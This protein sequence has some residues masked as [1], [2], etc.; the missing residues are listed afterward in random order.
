MPAHARARQRH[1]AL[2][3]DCDRHG[4][5]SEG[6]TEDE[7]VWRVPL[8]RRVHA[9]S[10]DRSGPT[11]ATAACS[12][13]TPPQPLVAAAE[14]AAANSRSPRS[15][16]TMAP[17]VSE[18]APSAARAAWAGPLR[19]ARRRRCVRIRC[20]YA[21]RRARGVTASRV[22]SG[23]RSGPRPWRSP[24]PPPY[25]NALARSWRARACA[26]VYVSGPARPSGAGC[27]S[28]GGAGGPGAMPEAPPERSPKPSSPNVH[29]R[30]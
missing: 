23:D 1:T 4:G 17:V 28:G 30:S 21:S 26:G 15:I 9:G 3:P 16:G 5:T 22:S 14:V 8:S 11:A 29:P 20:P 2:E 18:V 12:S 25:G 27:D 19:R 7:R 24:C 13:E 6:A 10:V